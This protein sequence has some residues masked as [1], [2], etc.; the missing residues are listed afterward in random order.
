MMSCIVHN[1][2]SRRIVGVDVGGANLKYA[3]LDRKSRATS[4]PLWRR[5]QDLA[6]QLALD[7]KPWLPV[8]LLAVTMTGELADCYIDREEG[9]LA[10]VAAVEQ[11]ANACRIPCV[12]YYAM[13]RG[14]IVADRAAEHIDDLAAANWHGLASYVRREFPEHTLLIDIGSTTT[15]ILPLAPEALSAVGTTDFERLSSGS[16]VYLGCERTPVCAILQSIEFRAQQVSLMNELFAMMDDAFVVLG[17]TP[18]SPTDYQSADGRARTQDFAAGRLARMIGLDRRQVTAD[19]VRLVAQ[20]VLDAAGQRIAKSL[21]RFRDHL[22]RPILSGH[23]RRLLP[24]SINASGYHLA[25]H[26]GE[27]LARVLPAY[28]VANLLITS[29]TKG[30]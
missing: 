27:D 15:D 21:D 30:S 10:I 3:S 13:H 24:A 19:E 11:A 9:V 28:A 16:L 7:L 4:F 29:E 17:L 23:G 6:P 14:F 25:D 18:E 22:S 20:Q 26:L 5:P 12:R 8:D 2:A 1:Q